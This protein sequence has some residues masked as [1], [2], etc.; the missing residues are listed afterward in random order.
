MDTKQFPVETL[1]NA[2]SNFEVEKLGKLH[3]ETNLGY[4]HLNVAELGR[5]IDFYQR[6]IGLRLEKEEQNRAYLGAG[7]DTLLVLS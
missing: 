3:G 7:S 5:S 4:V 6:S 2:G 1:E